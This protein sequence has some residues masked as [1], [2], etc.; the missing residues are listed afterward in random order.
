MT[1]KEIRTITGFSQAKFAE[2]YKI[3]KRTVESWEMGERQPPAYVLD[4]IEWRVNTDL[5]AETY[6][7]LK[8]YAEKIGISMSGA[9][10][11]AVIEYLKREE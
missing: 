7:R 2:R 8:A 4:L 9:L 1:I 11:K 5:R 10:D 3:P 6:K